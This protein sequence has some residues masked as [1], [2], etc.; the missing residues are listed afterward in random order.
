MQVMGGFIIGFDSDKEDIF[1][2]QISFI[3]KLGI[4]VA[5]VGLLT[6]L[7][8]TR[9]YHR[10]KKEG[11]LTGESPGGNTK[12]SINFIPKMNEE[13]MLREYK[14]L[15]RSINSVRSYYKRINNFLKEYRS[16]VRGGRLD[17]KDI[18]TFLKSLIFIGIF[19]RA[20]FFYWRLLF[21]TVLLKPKTLS[22]AV[23]LAIQGQHFR[24][25]AL[26]L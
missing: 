24:K 11:R 25:M 6:A 7:P 22:M 15:V 18:K 8:G 21:K 3:E 9:L 20:N 13:V 1:Q 19:S 10:L 12:A 2:K 14:N 4:V 16:T 23:E 26:N 17:W 5:M